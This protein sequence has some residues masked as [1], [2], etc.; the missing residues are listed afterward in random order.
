[1]KSVWV[2]VQASAGMKSGAREFLSSVKEKDLASTDHLNLH[3]LFLVE[4]ARNWRSYINFLEAQ[5][6]EMV[7]YCQDSND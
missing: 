7:R 6:V 4:L 5:L 2:I 1:M 3:L